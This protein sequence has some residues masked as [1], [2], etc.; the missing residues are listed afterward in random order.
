MDTPPS[1]RAHRWLLA[2]EDLWVWMDVGWHVSIAEVTRSSLT[3]LEPCALP[4][5]RPPPA[6]GWSYSEA[7]YPTLF[8]FLSHLPP[9]ENGEE[10]HFPQGFLWPSFADGGFV[11]QLRLAAESRG[12]LRLGHRLSVR[13][14]CLLLP[15][16][17]EGAFVS[18]RD[19]GCC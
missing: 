19:V 13:Q 11:V 18:L 8:L 9:W 17:K 16:I 3:A 5:P 14:D 10:G 6:H 7:F 4:P 2:L 12:S 1:P 15:G